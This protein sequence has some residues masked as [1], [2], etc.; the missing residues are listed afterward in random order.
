[1]YNFNVK[2]RLNM[3]ATNAARER[4][5]IRPGVSPAYPLSKAESNCFYSKWI[6]GNDTAHLITWVRNS[7]L[8]QKAYSSTGAVQNQGYRLIYGI[9]L[10]AV[11]VIGLTASIVR[12][13]L[14]VCSIYYLGKRIWEYKN[15]TGPFAAAIK[16]DKHQTINL[17]G[18][19]A[20]VQ[21]HSRAAQDAGSPL[22]DPITTD[23]YDMECTIELL[24]SQNETDESK[25]ID[26]SRSLQH[27]LERMRNH[28]YYASDDSI[29]V[30]V[31]KD[32]FERDIKRMKMIYAA[33]ASIY[34]IEDPFNKMIEEIEKR[35]PKL[36]QK[37]RLDGLSVEEL[38]KKKE[39]Y[40]Y[41][42]G[43]LSAPVEFTYPFKYEPAREEVQIVIKSSQGEDRVTSMPYH[44]LYNLEL[45]YDHCVR[46]CAEF[47]K[48]MLDP[49]EERITIQ[50][51]STDKSCCTVSNS[52]W[53]FTVS[54]RLINYFSREM[55]LSK[56]ER[57]RFLEIFGIEAPEDNTPQVEF[58]YPLAPSVAKKKKLETP[59]VPI[60]LVPPPVEE[61]VKEHPPAEQNKGYLQW[62]WE[63]LPGRSE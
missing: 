46:G 54:K 6:Y 8:A 56:E 13:F 62:L 18:Q 48:E 11:T 3:S 50:A 17:S 26:Y 53:S 12:N 58:R 31:R 44:F 4:T 34:E 42:L 55:C 47:G 27:W 24:L 40:Q 22:K 59:E 20:F 1:M 23:E 36:E 14:A 7:R 61:T 5:I 37:Y 45:S 2:L 10:A 19:S 57:K 38:E 35:W 43:V 21:Y 49:D 30:Y 33:F 41:I 60:T 15:G 29:S 25:K 52:S 16:G 32:D 63:M 28:L 51:P 39:D 9:S